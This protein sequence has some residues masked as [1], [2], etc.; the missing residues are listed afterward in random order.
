MN[1][2]RIARPLLILILF[3]C[4]AI[5]PLVRPPTV[6]YAQT[7]EPFHPLPTPDSELVQP[8]E[9]NSVYELSDFAAAHINAY[10]YN[11]F[12]AAG[13]TY[14]PPQE[15]GYFTEP[16]PCGTY[17]LSLGNAWYCPQRHLIAYDPNFFYTQWVT[18]G[19]FAVF[20]ILAHEWGHLVQAHFGLLGQEYQELQADCFA[21]NYAVYAEQSGILEEG[22][23][24][25]AVNTLFS[26]GDPNLPAFSPNTHGRPEERNNAFNIGYSY[27]PEA[28]FTYYTGRPSGGTGGAG[29][30]GGYYPVYLPVVIR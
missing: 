17:T 2:I 3:L 30:A 7:N 16:L 9:W 25:E 6:I 1:V 26:I 24:Q 11:Q 28:G 29:F 19:D 5:S 22:D 14:S 18:F 20:T 8:Q 4:V 15:Y 13:V 10:W 27:G 23:L 12:T 21:G